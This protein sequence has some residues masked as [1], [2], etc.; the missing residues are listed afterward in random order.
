V[1][2]LGD[3]GEGTG[4]S[5]SSTGMQGAG[6]QTAPTVASGGPVCGDGNI[7][8]PETCDSN[9]PAECIDPDLCTSQQPAGEP[10]SCNV[11]CP[12]TP[13][14]ACKNG[15]GCCPPGCGPNNDNDCA[16]RILV[17][18]SQ[19]QPAAAGMLKFVMPSFGQIDVKVY[20]AATPPPT[21]SVLASYSAV[22][23][24]LNVPFPDPKI[25]GDLLADYQD[26]GGRVV[27]GA[28]AD[29]A[30]S[31]RV[32]GR[33]DTEGYILFSDG[34]GVLPGATSIGEIDEPQSPLMVGVQQFPPQNAH[35]DAVLLPGASAVARYA[36]GRPLLARGRVH[37]HMRVDLNFMPNSSD[38]SLWT[39]VANALRYPRD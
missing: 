38:S 17:L 19:A 5:G 22:L 30:D 8:V 4:A 39:L 20:D 36:D 12:F 10:T 29:C 35:C 31:F 32:R 25:V 27:L 16:E 26:A 3:Y 28:G 24:Y 2:G 13:I 18:S 37:G 11:F 21:A 7:D 1:L 9:C 14:A 33:F 34:A 6:G 15:D 23:V